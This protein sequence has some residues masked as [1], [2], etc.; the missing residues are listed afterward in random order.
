[1]Q[2][3]AH[4]FITSLPLSA[5]ALR[6][7]I[8]FFITAASLIA[9]LLLL[10][11]SFSSDALAARCRAVY[12]HILPPLF[13]ILHLLG[14]PTSL[15]VLL[16]LI[17]MTIVVKSGALGPAKHADHPPG[18]IQ[19]EKHP[20]RFLKAQL[21]EQFDVERSGGASAPEK[22]QEQSVGHKLQGLF[23]IAALEMDHIPCCLEEQESIH[24]TNAEDRASFEDQDQ[25]TLYDQNSHQAQT[26][27]SFP[28]VA[29]QLNVSIDVDKKQERDVRRSLFTV[30][31][32]EN[33]DR[34]RLARCSSGPCLQT[35]LGNIS[36]KNPKSAAPQ[37]SCVGHQEMGL[38]EQE[39]KSLRMQDPARKVAANKVV[40]MEGSNVNG[41]P[42]ENLVQIGELEDHKHTEMSAEELNQRAEAYL[43]KFRRFLSIERQDSFNR[44]YGLI[45]GDNRLR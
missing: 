21:P 38:Q 42:E 27:D 30:E 39:A 10:S 31:P 14:L 23:T 34:S 43:S 15:Y 8:F 28:K 7:P 37:N 25:K 5:Y 12:D 4:R 16:N 36:G 18:L 26:G 1:M 3:S 24:A 32:L 33:V 2:F 44:L 22:M 20:V 29:A 6:K 17:F 9:N 40:V 19:P 45:S 35:V 13:M 11:N 41:S